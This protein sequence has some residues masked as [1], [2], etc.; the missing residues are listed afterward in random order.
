M[1]NFI[2][3]MGKS[4][5]GKDTIFSLLKNRIKSN[6]YIPYTTRPKRRGEKEGVTY[7]FKTK[8][9]FEMIEKSGKVMEKRSYNIIDA[10]GNPD[11]WTYATVFDNQFNSRG[12]Y[13]TIGTLESYVSIVNYLKIHPEKRLKMLPIYITVDEIER[14]KRARKREEN[15]E[16]PNYKEM[17]RRLIADNIDF[18]DENLKKANIRKEDTF[19]NYDLDK[20]VDSIVNHILTIQKNKDEYER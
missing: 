18:S 11:I 20:C 10:N 19:E 14:E 2:Y 8:E 6:I 4:S 12:D 1:S 15:Q 9:E 3:I 13:M 16:K 5:S 17:K 7:F